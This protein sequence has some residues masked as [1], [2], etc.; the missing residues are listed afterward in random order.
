MRASKQKKLRQAFERQA[1]PQLDAMYGMALRLT[2]DERDAEDLVQDAM[3]K[4]YRFFDRFEQGSNIKAWLFKVLV[5][6]FY[7][8]VRKRKNIQRLHTEAETASH[9]ERFVSEA[10]SSAMNAEGALLDRLVGERLQKAIDELPE[11]FRVAV[12]LCDVHDLSYREIAEVMDCP[13]GTV[14]SRLYRARRQLQRRL[15]DY[16]VEQGYIRPREPAHG[17]DEGPA[18]LAAYRRRRQEGN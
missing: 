17:D 4:A 11:E 10:S 15:Y 13:V 1:L 6:T 9:Y 16:A 3:V 5:N 2:Q 7:N 8:S 12:T 14:M 18:D